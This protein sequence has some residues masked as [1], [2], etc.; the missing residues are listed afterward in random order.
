MLSEDMEAPTAAEIAE[1]ESIVDAERYPLHRPA[2]P[3]RRELLEVCRAGLEREGCAHVSNFLRPAAL[4]SARD[5]SNELAR[6]AFY[7]MERVNP[8]FTADDPQ[9]PVDHPR[10]WFMDRTSG[11]VTLDQFPESSLIRR[12]YFS[13]VMKRFVADCLGEAVLYEYADPFAG[14]V[15]NCVD[16][17]TQQ[18]WHYDTNE[19]I[20]SI[21]T[22]E[23]ES[24]G[25]FEYCP[26]IRTA[27]DENYEGVGR[28]LKGGRE[29]V[30]RLELRPGDLQLFKGRFSLHRVT[31]VTGTTPR[32]TAILAYSQL[33]GVIGRVERT[34]QLYGRVTQ[35][36]I[37]AEKNPTRADALTD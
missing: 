1:F 19:F 24:G 33:P 13:P 12:L 10:R 26:N 18:P 14:L 5:E 30:V 28:V 29:E 32:Y 8:Y 37:D 22:Q 4:A 15:I 35:A 23:S 16:P 11:F 31:E 27:A 6:E 3:L 17:G 21:M 7:S 25:Y 34:R 36:H 9:L 2:D 20:V